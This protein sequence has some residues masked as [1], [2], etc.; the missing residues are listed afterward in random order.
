MRILTRKSKRS[1]NSV[2]AMILLGSLL[3]TSPVYSEPL[4]IGELA[5]DLKKVEDDVN[6]L[7]HDIDEYKLQAALLRTSIVK[8]GYMLQML[9]SYR[10]QIKEE[11]EKFIGFTDYLKQIKEQFPGQYLDDYKT[12]GQPLIETETETTK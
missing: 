2:T 12:T 5:R 1:A 8:T 6:P 11:A 7:Q 3:I 4:T 9:G 10:D